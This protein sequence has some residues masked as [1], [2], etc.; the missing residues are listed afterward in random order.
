MPLWFKPTALRGR[1]GSTIFWVSVCSIVLVGASLAA[2]RL[3]EP[4]WETRYHGFVVS[5]YPFNA[6]NYLRHGYLTTKLGPV[7]NPGADVA[8]EEFQYRASH[9]NVTALLI[10][11]AYQIFGVSYWSA[12]LVPLLLALGVSALTFLL[13]LQLTRDRLA[14][15]AALLF[16][17]LSPILTFYGR[18]P[19]PH[20]LAVFFVLLAFLF[21]W[22]W[23]QHGRRAEMY[24]VFVALG[25][26]AWTDW[27]AYFGFPALL[28]HYLCF[29]WREHGWRFALALLVAPLVCFLSYA[30][31]LVALN[32][33]QTLSSLRERFL[34][35]TVSS[36]S[37][38]FAFLGSEVLTQF[39]AKAD[40]LL[41][42]PVAILGFVWLLLFLRSAWRRQVTAAEGLIFALF[43]FGGTHNLV[44]QN[45]I[46]IHEFIMFYQLVPAF[47]IAAGVTLSRAVSYLK[48]SFPVVAS[49][50]VLGVGALFVD[51]A[52]H[53]YRALHEENATSLWPVYYLGR[54]LDQSLP[55]SGR[56]LTDITNSW[57]ILANTADRAYT[58]AASDQLLDLLS[59]QA[60]DAVVIDRRNPPAEAVITELMRRY[61]SE[62][63]ADYSV[64]YTAPQNAGGQQ[65]LAATAQ[66]AFPARITFGGNLEYLGYDI[67]SEVLSRKE[68]TIAWYER[69]LS[70]TPELL[71]HRRT[72]LR[73]THYWRRLSAD[74]V[75]YTLVTD[76]IDPFTGTYSGL[77]RQSR[78]GWQGIL[79]TSAWPVG[80]VVRDEMVVYLP[81][82]A[83]SLR[84]GLRVGVRLG[85][86]PLEAIDG[87]GRAGPEVGLVGKVDVRPA[88]PQPAWAGVVTPAYASDLTI[89]SSLRLIG[90]DLTSA[91]RGLSVTSYWA[92][93]GSAD[94]QL[95]LQLGAEHTALQVPLA[96]LVPRLWVAG[97]V[98]RITTP[99][100]DYLASGVHDLSLVIVDEQG[101]RSAHRLSEVA[102]CR[103]QGD[104]V[105][106]SDVGRPGRSSLVVSPDKPVE[107]SFMLSNP[108]EVGVIVAFT[109]RSQLDYTVAQIQAYNAKWALGTH[110]TLKTVEVMRGDAQT[111]RVSVPRE[112]TVRGMN[113]IQI[114]IPGR[115]LVGWR[116]AVATVLPGVAPSLRD[117]PSPYRGWLGLDTVQVV[118]G[119]PDTEDISAYGLPEILTL[120]SH[121]EAGSYCADANTIAE[122]D[123]A[124]E[125]RLGQYDWST[126]T[127]A[128]L[129]TLQA[130]ASFRQPPGLRD[131]L[132]ANGGA[133]Q[134]DRVFSG[135]GGEKFHV[136]GYT[137]TGLDT[138]GSA[139]IAL[140]IKALG[141]L[142][143]SDA[144]WLHVRASDRDDL[145][146]VSRD[147]G[148]INIDPRP[149]PA[150]ERW[151]PGN[152]YVVERD[153]PDLK[154]SYSLAFGLWNV[155]R[156]KLYTVSDEQ[157]EVRIELR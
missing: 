89:D 74:P 27:V 71:P 114:S 73:I 125:G 126:V 80:Q 146:A 105:V 7:E 119:L 94:Y 127:T 26:G 134:V 91:E 133:Q 13:T 128:D 142:E 12:R 35:R 34:F 147:L 123:R 107:L 124:I 130:R 54:H 10:S 38:E 11:F 87:Q 1:L 148:F 95:H 31:W 112:L 9:G 118:A 17:A 2:Y 139:K 64:F 55:E 33:V 151:Q 153:L 83:S 76:F 49:A 84:Y 104:E 29:F 113:T 16:C 140:Y 69:Y 39:F 5:E 44:F 82:Q 141:N 51:Q 131:Y 90:Y 20:N 110:R 18:L 70:S 156:G 77:L 99:I 136:L 122:L 108:Q 98:Y 115:A 143:P 117:G 30:L 78:S 154:E 102:W 79:P 150:L 144:L 43:V 48:P 111:V 53:S 85:D 45:R 135:E 72:T 14:S 86:E 62:P 88:L 4:P 37:E 25:V 52:I 24:L 137:L 23:A 155:E 157:S 41:T 81:E 59:S 75:D 8:P 58:V 96:A 57:P 28:L 42:M 63:V 132:L 19:G 100:P 138:P 66:P 92:G 121:L 40:L 101:Q 145:P 21:Y 97:E 47:A 68:D 50:A 149:I 120:R 106:L 6:A 22:R 61:P 60:F 129:L 152:V 67:E 32:P 93:D 36:G 65:A 15:L 109:G 116:A 56:Y 103:A 3:G 46:M